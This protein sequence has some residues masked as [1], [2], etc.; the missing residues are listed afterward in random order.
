MILRKDKWYFD[1]QEQKRKCQS[2]FSL[3]LSWLL[4]PAVAYVC[5]LLYEM[6]FSG[7]VSA[8]PVRLDS[9]RNQSYVK[10]YTKSPH[11][12]RPAKT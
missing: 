4:F 7:E 5:L 8:Q 12:S 9:P 1:N 6:H 10:W 3:P 2:F 11:T